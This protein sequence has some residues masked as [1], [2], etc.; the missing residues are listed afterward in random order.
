M[1]GRVSAYNQAQKANYFMIGNQVTLL[2]VNSYTEGNAIGGLGVIGSYNPPLNKKADIE[3]TVSYNTFATNTILGVKLIDFN[4]GGSSVI[5]DQAIASA[6][7]QQVHNF[8][9]SMQ[10][11]FNVAFTGTSVAN[12]GALDIFCKITELPV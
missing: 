7:A 5:L 4:A 8:K 1:V 10:R 9:F 12:D 3:C 11:G 2:D 6:G